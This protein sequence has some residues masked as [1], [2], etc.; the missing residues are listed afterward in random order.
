MLS[1]DCKE[2]ALVGRS[3]LWH[4]PLGSLSECCR[5]F[6]DFCVMRIAYVTHKFYVPSETFV[7]DRALGLAGLGHSVTLVCDKLNASGRQAKDVE[8]RPCH[9]R[10][11]RRTMH[12]G[13]PFRSLCESLDHAVGVALLRREFVRAKAE[14]V[15][16]D[17]GTNAIYAVEAAKSL[18]LPI[19]SSFHGFDITASLRSPSYCRRLK[20]VLEQSDAMIVPSRHIRSLL[21]NAGAPAEKIHVIAAGV[22]LA[23]CPVPDWACKRT[24][25]PTVLSIGRLVE[26]KNPTGLVDAFRI[27]HDAMPQTRLVMVGD[28]PLKDDVLR[29]VGEQGLEGVVTLT[30]AQ[31][32][33][34]ALEHLSA[35]WVFAQHSVTAPNGDQEGLPVSVMEACACGVPVVATL[36]SGIPEA[37]DE[38]QTGYLVREHDLAAMGER[39]LQLLRNPDE[40]RRMGEN[41]R[42]R[43]LRDFDQHLCFT[44]VEA[45]LK[46]ILKGSPAHDTATEV[47]EPSALR[48]NA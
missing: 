13:G 43:A 14:V 48:D 22:N 40:A 26:K 11:V 42:A 6:D 7:H 23:Y 8:L 4:V 45:V 18:G 34:V 19:A 27:V 12:W 37:I 16:V 10:I 47:T 2:C 32:H 15:Y 35:A 3:F 38:G 17:F 20:P 5:L 9:F 24:G 25:A 30:G 1:V 28:G 29:R 39:I 41:G 44:R 21:E 33:S 31:P 36:H 46:G